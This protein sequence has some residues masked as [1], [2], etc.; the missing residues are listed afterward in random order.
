MKGCA[1]G[2]KSIDTGTGRNSL[3]R[4]LRD[5][6]G[7]ECS[8]WFFET[9]KKAVVRICKVKGGCIL[10]GSSNLVF[11]VTANP[12]IRVLPND[13]FSDFVIRKN[14]NHVRKR[15]QIPVPLH[16]L[17]SKGNVEWRHI[18]EQQAD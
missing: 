16:G 18:N 6:W 11:C 1:G 12:T 7:G 8:I 14:D 4:T 13:Q 10:S 5:V 15:G 9:R 17:G 3:G 2:A